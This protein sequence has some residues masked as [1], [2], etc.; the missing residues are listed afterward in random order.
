MQ[1]STT[2]R[3]MHAAVTRGYHMNKK[4]WI[5]LESGGSIDEKLVEELVTE[6]YR[7][8]VGNLPRSDRPVDPAAYG[9]AARAARP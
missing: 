9:T 5:T 2:R 3:E 7:L 8:V 6:S 4:H 1:G